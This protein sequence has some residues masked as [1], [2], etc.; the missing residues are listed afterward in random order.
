LANNKLDRVKYFKNIMVSAF[1]VGTIIC[2]NGCGPGKG[3]ILKMSYEGYHNNLQWQKYREASLMVAIEKQE[4]FWE[5]YGIDHR[6][7]YRAFQFDIESVIWMGEESNQAKV[8]I[9]RSYFKAPSVTVK[10]EMITQTWEYNE[11]IESWFLVEGF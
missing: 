4:A 1:I 6:D 2:F 3:E 7:T 8:I 11:E 5:Q 9:R 10:K